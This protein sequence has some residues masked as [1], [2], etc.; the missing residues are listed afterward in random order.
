MR[1]PGRGTHVCHRNRPPHRSS[2]HRSSPLRSCPH[3]S[4]AAGAHRR[5]TR[6]LAADLAAHRE[7]WED[8]LEYDE[9]ERWYSLLAAGE[10]Y[11]VWLL[12]WS[13]GQST[14]LHDHGGSSGAFQVLQGNLVETTVTRQPAGPG[15]MRSSL[16][17]LA[18]GD[19]RS[20]G[21]AYVHDV[22]HSGTGPAA[23]LHV[24]SPPLSRM[25]Y[26]EITGT[27]L[28]TVASDA[29]DVPEPGW[30]R[31]PGAESW[32]STP[33]RRSI[34]DI[35]ASARARLDRLDPVP[36]YDAWQ[37]GAVLVDIRPAAQRAAEGEV[38][39]ALLVE[40][41]VLEWRFD[42]ESSARLPEATGY[43]QQVLVLCQEG[44]TSSLAAASLQDI[45]LHRAT[46]VAGGF[47]AW[48]AAGLPATGPVGAD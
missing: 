17:E 31:R 8:Q 7:L 27:G 4:S 42:P 24:Y 9:H 39:G 23:S 45:G 15:A 20:F 26:Y 32:R 36:A 28:R 10:L 29:T 41:N 46:D 5:C 35:L 44:F 6:R 47:A 12:S 13:P 38:P 33:E 25:N 11:D 2:P 22:R 19:A 34:A 48:V 3:R 43:D 30:P 21:P 40:R 1:M 14:S 37:D 16:R 18:A